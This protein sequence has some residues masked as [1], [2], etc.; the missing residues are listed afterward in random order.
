MFAIGLLATILAILLICA[1]RPIAAPA[2]PLTTEELRFLCP[3]ERDFC[4]EHSKQGF[5]YGKSIKAKL[6]SK[7]CKCSCANAHHRRIQNCCRTVGDHDMRFCLPLCGYNTTAN[8]LGSGLGLKCI[9]QLTIW[10]YCAADAND[11]TECCKRKG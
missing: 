7:Q 4:H 8:D 11:N 10:T 6:L 2:S 5:C 1:I 3:E 9:T